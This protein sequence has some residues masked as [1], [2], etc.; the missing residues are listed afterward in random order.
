MS[1]GSHPVG[2]LPVLWQRSRLK[3]RVIS[4]TSTNSSSFRLEQI[5]L[6]RQ[7]SPAIPAASGTSARCWNVRSALRGAN[8][9]ASKDSSRLR[10]RIK[11]QDDGHGMDL[12]RIAFGWLVISASS[13]RSTTGYKE[14]TKRFGRTPL[15]DKGLGRLP[16]PIYAPARRRRPGPSPFG[17]TMHSADPP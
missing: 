9:G 12:T 2:R 13:K 6:R 3:G 1:M 16:D 11:V 7:S 14:V 5:A 15:G 8:A 17:V 10:G 4:R